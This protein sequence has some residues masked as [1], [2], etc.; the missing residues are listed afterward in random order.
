MCSCSLLGLGQRSVWDKENK[1]KPPDSKYWQQIPRICII[2]FPIQVAIKSDTHLDDWKPIT[3]QRTDNK[4]LCAHW[5]FLVDLT[6][7]TN[8]FR[9]PDSVLQRC[10]LQKRVNMSLFQTESNTSAA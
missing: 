8:V 7:H 6:A 1:I 10:S 2:V 5:G 4:D 3:A 9:R